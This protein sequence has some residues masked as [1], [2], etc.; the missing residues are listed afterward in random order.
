MK[1]NSSRSAPNSPAPKSTPTRSGSACAFAEIGIPSL[2]HHNFRRSL[3]TISTPR[4][5]VSRATSHRDRWPRSTSTTDARL[6][7]RS[8]HLYSMSRPSSIS[9]I[10][11]PNANARCGTQSRT[12]DVARRAEVVVNRMGRA[13]LYDSD[14]ARREKERRRQGGNKEGESIERYLPSP[15]LPFSFSPL[16]YAGV[17]PKCTP[18]T[19][20]K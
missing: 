16:R 17:L 20:S 13:G 7:P 3:T 5:A 15:F 6:L 1:Q 11:S 18:C 8:R 4:I 14:R 10:S 12:S 19:K 9:N 2:A